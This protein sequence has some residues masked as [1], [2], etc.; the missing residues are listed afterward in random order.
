MSVK[1]IKVSEET[2]GIGGIA[3]K[4]ENWYSK[5]KDF[6]QLVIVLVK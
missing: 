6:M 4:I 2:R 5:T 3:T 1:T